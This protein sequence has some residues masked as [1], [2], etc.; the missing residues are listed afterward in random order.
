LQ[1]I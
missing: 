1:F